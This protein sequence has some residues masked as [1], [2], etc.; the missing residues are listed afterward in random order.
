MSVKKS[1]GIA[2]TENRL[3]ILNRKNQTHGKLNIIDKPNKKGVRV[4]LSLPLE[5]SF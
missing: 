4:E 5:Y 1:F 2:I 3:N